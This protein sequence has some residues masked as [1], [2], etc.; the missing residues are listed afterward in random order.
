MI[1]V[2]FPEMLPLAQAIAR[3][4][5][6]TVLALNW[7]HFPD[8]ESLVTL[9]E[10]LDGAEIAIVINL[11]DPDRSALP[12][13]FAAETA[14]ELGAG[15]VGLIAP[16]LGYMRQDRRFAPG[17]AISAPLFARFLGESFDWLITVDPHLHRIKSLNE[18]FSVPAIRVATAPLIA[19]WI[20][21]EVPDAVLIGPDNES[22]QWVAEV[23]AMARRPFEVLGKQRSGDRSV[24]V[25]LPRVADLGSGTPVL[26]DDI[27]SSGQTMVR[28]VDRVLA[29]GGRAPV[30]V[31]IHAVL[32]GSAF[33]D[34][35]SAGAARIVTTDTI[36]H[37]SN[38]ISI[39]GSI[40]TALAQVASNSI[41]QEPN[42]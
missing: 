12:L 29:A 8:G 18:V 6:G 9:P 7:H 1:F 32:A 33:E 25:T 28:A 17:Q 26:L 10:G 3:H 5:G 22:R 31:L 36:P 40:A 11:R 30:C 19:D 23:A 42:T 37:A 15:R 13:R 21:S 4:S 14:R 16:Y 27:A 39:A 41:T 2:A 20:A 35:L 24:E 38:A 34:I